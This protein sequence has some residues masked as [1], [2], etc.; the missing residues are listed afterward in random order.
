MTTTPS[1]APVSIGQYI[2]LGQSGSGLRF[3]NF[4]IGQ[5]ATFDGNTYGFL[6]FGFSGATANRAGEN[7][8]SFLIFP[9]TQPT[10]VFA[11]NALD[12]NWTAVVNVV[13]IASED[14]S[15]P[16]QGLYQYIGQI[17]GSTWTTGEISMKLSSVLDAVTAQ[18]PRRNLTQSDV[19]FL[20]ITGSLSV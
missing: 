15:N 10:R 13:L 7:S 14:P 1:A 9:N 5:N 11:E 6:P 16:P 19:G 12:Q 8:E 17:T 4:F 3:Q 18:V 20:P 2:T